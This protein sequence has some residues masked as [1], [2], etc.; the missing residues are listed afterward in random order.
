M[1]DS[2]ASFLMTKHLTKIDAMC[3]ANQTF[4]MML[5]IDQYRMVQRWISHLAVL[6]RYNDDTYL[7]LWEY[8][9][10]NT[11]VRFQRTCLVF[12][13]VDE[14]ENIIIVTAKSMGDCVEENERGQKPPRMLFSCSFTYASQPSSSTDGFY[15]HLAGEI[16][17]GSNLGDR[18][19]IADALQYALRWENACVAPL[20]QLRRN[21]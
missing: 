16:D 4:N 5:S 19:V 6:Y 15:V 21:E 18:R 10:P 17:T 1:R 11:K 13:I 8:S 3:T 9:D 12:R 14:D 20:F 2:G 7:V